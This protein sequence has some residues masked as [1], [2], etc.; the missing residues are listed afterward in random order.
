MVP[1]ADADDPGAVGAELAVGVAVAARP[2][3]L[4]GE[5]DGR[6]AGLE[7][8]QALVGP[9]GEPHHTVAHPPRG[10][11]VLVDGR[12]RVAALG[13]QLVRTT[14]GAAADQLRAPALARAALGPHD[15][16]TVDPHLTEADGRG[17]DDL[18]GHRCG[19]RAE[20]ALDGGIGVRDRGDHHIGNAIRDRWRG[21]VTCA[22]RSREPAPPGAGTAAGAPGAAPGP[23]AGPGASGPHRPA[24]RVRSPECGTPAWRRAGPGALRAAPGHGTSATRTGTRSRDGRSRTTPAHAPQAASWTTSTS[25]T[26]ASRYDQAA[27]VAT[28]RAPTQVQASSGR[29]TGSAAAHTAVHRA[30]VAP[31]VRQH[32][33]REPACCEAG[34]DEWGDRQRHHQHDRREHEMRQ[35]RG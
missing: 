7:P 13:K 6:R 2:G 3:R 16:R 17:D 12:A 11:A 9:V 8:V 26:A 19:P 1:L 30:V 4:G 14:V 31:G 10:A 21:R 27:S 22:G 23:P 29:T 34:R 20:G 15:V 5:R 28:V 25:L 35:G 24:R 33:H 32:R 18:G